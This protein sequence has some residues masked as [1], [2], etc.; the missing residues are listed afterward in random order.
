MSDVPG[1]KEEDFEDVSPVDG[2]EILQLVLM[3]DT[4]SSMTRE[5]A[6]A[7]KTLVQIVE[8]VSA[9]AEGKFAAALQAMDAQ[10]DDSPA[11]AAVSL[12]RSATVIDAAPT[13][14]Q[15]PASGNAAPK[16]QAVW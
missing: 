8:T 13:P 11:K 4:T 6:M 2:K 10:L 5:I 14:V 1:L 12:Q 16:Q 9:S 7:R 15:A 3:L